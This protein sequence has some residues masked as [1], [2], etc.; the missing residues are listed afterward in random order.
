MLLAREAELAV[1]EEAVRGVRPGPGGVLLIGGS[2]GSGRTALLRRLGVIGTRA[3]A[4]VLWA[5]GVHGERGFPL[6]VVRQLFLP[7]LVPDCEVAVSAATRRMLDPLV[8][9]SP[10]SERTEQAPSELARV[11]HGLHALSAEISAAEPVLLLVDDLHWADEPSSRALAFLAARLRGLRLLIGVV[12]PDG[13]G[14][15]DPLI[16]EIAGAAAHHVR[17]EPLPLEAVREL[18]A[19]QFGTDHDEEFARACHDLTGG[20]CA[21][22]RALLNRASSQ[23]LRGRAADLD[24]L[25]ESAA[26]FRQERLCLLLRRDADVAAVAKAVAVL[27]DR[28]ELRV[29]RRLAEVDTWRFPAALAALADRWL[30][31][32]GEHVGILDPGLPA[33]VE[34]ML[35]PGES[36]ELHRRAAVVLDRSGR[37]PE[38]V[39]AQLLGVDLV[40]EGWETDQLCAAAAAARRRGEPAV[41]SRYLRRAVRDLP[42]DSADRACLLVEL[43]A[44]EQD[45]DPGVAFR[46]LAQAAML[47]PTGR[48][49]AA[50]AAR[51]PL[52]AAGDGTLVFELVRDVAERLGPADD[53]RGH[54]RDLAMRLEARLRFAGLGD[55]AKLADAVDRLAGL[56]DDGH[57]PTPAERELRTVLLMAATLR[58]ATTAESVAGRLRDVLEQEPTD[59]YGAMT[60][61]QLAPAILLATDSVDLGWSWVD[62]AYEHA[63]RHSN[64]TPQA[65]VGA[66]RG[67]LL[68][69]SGRLAEARVQAERAFEL[70]D[71]SWPDEAMVL[72]STVLALVALAQRDTTLATRVLEKAPPA[73]DL[74]LMETRSSLSGALAVERGDLPAALAQFLDCGRLL[75]SAGWQNPAM[76]PWRSWAAVLSHR[77]G[78]TGEAVRL[79]EENYERALAW[80]APTPLGRALRIRALIH[81]GSARAVALLRE[82]NEVLSTSPNRLERAKSLIRLGEALRDT[83]RDEADRLLARGRRTAEQ[84][85]AQW[86]GE[87]AEDGLHIMAGSTGSAPVIRPE[88]TRGE[89]VVAELA[90]R[91]RTNAEIAEELTISRRAVE[92]HLTSSY[93]KLNITGRPGLAAALGL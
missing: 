26:A 3:G 74:W 90:A 83:N 8:C 25:R 50:V 36:A 33:A 54:D 91:G 75:E 21:E 23:L 44:V 39:A 93:R 37:P 63:R 60:A 76:H 78:R 58:S 22:L 6:G 89:A 55:P 71:R 2:A 46:H 47:M 27:G 30:E 92:K 16:R 80:G 11:L 61:L 49:R 72:P 14:T 53:L 17:A 57:W 18:V 48:E 43:A 82:S 81:R 31:V 69:G 4:R 70:T 51:I 85:G 7:L 77:M 86:L 5:G 79:A 20:D 9:G 84:C 73:K 35:G 38:D 68:L 10:P 12:L 42:P 56:P 59:S 45:A 87:A 32:S 66:Q 65:L 41:A 19:A 88:L 62:S 1:L 40:R 64:S 13:A 52:P 24:R 29:V 34:E 67:L 28:A 15:R